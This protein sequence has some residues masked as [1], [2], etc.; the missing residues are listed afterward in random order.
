[1]PITA[2]GRFFIDETGRRRILHGVNLSGA[3]KVP[4]QPPGATHLPDS[5]ADP[6]NVSFIGRPFPLDEADEHFARLKHWGLDCLRFIVTWEALAHAG[7]GCIDEAYLDYLVAVLEKAQAHDL[8]AFIDPHQD[9]WS[10]FCGGD[11][12]PAW[13]FDAVGMDIERFSETGAATLHQQQP[14]SFPQLMWANNYSRYACFT[15]FTLFFGGREFAPQLQVDGQN[16][17]DYLQGHYCAAY[18]TLARRLRDLPNLLGFGSMNE[19][20]GGLLGVPDLRSNAHALIRLGLVAQS[21][22]SDLPR[23]WLRS[24]LF[25]LSARRWSTGCPDR[26]SRYAL[27]HKVRQSG[28]MARTMSGV[29][30]ESGMWTALASRACCGLGTSRAPTFCS[31]FLKPFAERF[32]SAIHA[33]VPD[34]LIFVEAEPMG[35]PPKI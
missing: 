31:D 29:C 10:R 15:M 32:A 3:S 16:I 4:A 20:S 34:A 27:T 8:L 17:Q 12:A 13:T 33:E 23:Q 22:A 1:M 19:P 18:S 26:Q 5:L 9:V 25:G 35:P 7:P 2:A 28:A 21:G 24:R 6:C 30:T 11:G 14:D